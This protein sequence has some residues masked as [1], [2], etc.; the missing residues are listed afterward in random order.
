M[1]KLEDIIFGDYDSM[2]IR[3]LIFGSK[4]KGIS[5]ATEHIDESRRGFLGKAATGIAALYLANGI[6]AVI[7]YIAKEN[8]SMS[9]IEVQRIA[10]EFV[11]GIGPDKAEARAPFGA[12]DKVLPPSLQDANVVNYSLQKA[13]LYW[14]RAKK[15]KLYSIIHSSWLSSTKLPKH[16]YY[17]DPN[18][19]Y[20]KKISEWRFKELVEVPNEIEDLKTE[21]VDFKKLRGK[22]EPLGWFAEAIDGHVNREFDLPSKFGPQLDYMKVAELAAKSYITACYYNEIQSKDRRYQNI[23]RNSTKLLEYINKMDENDYVKGLRNNLLSQP[24][25]IILT[26]AWAGYLMTISYELSS[27]QIIVWDRDVKK[28]IYPSGFILSNIE[29]PASKRYGIKIDQAEFKIRGP[30]KLYLVK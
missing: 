11:K 23:D 27:K 25:H 6:G 15:E 12:N 28:P 18:Y 10:N 14:R 16:V 2:G 17:E 13:F 22:N 24:A 19:Y 8:P 21:L 29:G 20:I 1:D 30:P 9:Q 7:N 26:A 4:D 5:Q 3:E